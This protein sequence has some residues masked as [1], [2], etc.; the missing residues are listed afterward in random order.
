MRRESGNAIALPHSGAE[1]PAHSRKRRLSGA[2]AMT[3]RCCGRGRPGN[4]SVASALA[5]S[6]VA[7]CWSRGKKRKTKRPLSS[8]SGASR[9]G[10]QSVPIHH[11]NS[12]NFVRPLVCRSCRLGKLGQKGITATGTSQINVINGT[13]LFDID[14]ASSLTSSA[15]HL[16]NGVTIN[17]SGNTVTLKLQLALFPHES[18]AVQVTGVVPIGKVLPLLNG[19]QLTLIGGQSPL[20]V[21]V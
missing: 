11:C 10:L 8:R 15:I 13:V 12:D 14:S 2:M 1:V 21:V 4:V 17:S 20:A 3:T 18:W 6:D 9:P 7:S 19:L 5:A 16:A